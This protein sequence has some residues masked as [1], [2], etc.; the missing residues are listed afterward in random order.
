MTAF[1]EHSDKIL[2]NREMNM[3]VPLEQ[4]EFRDLLVPLIMNAGTAVINGRLGMTCNTGDQDWGDVGRRLM[5][6]P[7]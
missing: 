3:A 7:I 2:I 1:A 5:P 4:N 6:E